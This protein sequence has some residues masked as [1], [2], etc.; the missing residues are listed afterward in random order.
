MIDNT[1]IL[2]VVNNGIENTFSKFNKIIWGEVVKVKEKTIDIQPSYKGRYNEKDRDLPLLVDVP[3][4]FLQGGGSYRADPI[5]E[6]DFAL[7]FIADRCIEQWYYGNNNQ[8]P[9][10]YRMNDLA[11][12]FAIVGINQL[13][14]AITIPDVITEIGDKFK[15]GDCEHIGDINHQGNY[16]Q[17]GDFT[18][19]GNKLINGNFVVNGASGGG[20]ASMNNTTFNLPSNSDLIITTRL[21]NVSLRAFIESH[22]HKGDSGG[23]TGTPII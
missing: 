23:D 12:A 13:L 14:T 3:P 8:A 7:V 9:R 18:Q 4:I 15:K 10:Q 2:E 22:Y 19:N 1:K 5:K 20:Q 6:G 21:G 17:E 16:I 11:D